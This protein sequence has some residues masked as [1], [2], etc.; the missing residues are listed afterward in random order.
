MMSKPNLAF[1]F[2]RYARDLQS[3]LKYPIWCLQGRP[4]PD[5]HVYKKRRIRRLARENRCDTFI[6]TGTFYGQMVNFARRIFRTI[7]SVEIYPPFHRE[8]VAQFLHDPDVNILF[9]DS[10]KNLPEAISIASGRILFWL[11]GHYSGSGTGIGEKVSP[12]IEELRLIAKAGRKD[13]C[14]VI[15][16]KRLFTGRDGYPTMAETISEL[17][18]INSTYEISTDLDSIIACPSKIARV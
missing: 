1:V 15:D 2:G 4:A 13:D 7:I 8:N 5:N 6:E 14:I 3:A 11:D 12:I 10:G 17:K 9:G 16:D 18:A